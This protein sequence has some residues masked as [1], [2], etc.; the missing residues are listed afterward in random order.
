MFR[1]K[2]ANH[3]V[4]GPLSADAIRQLIASGV[5]GRNSLLQEGGTG[6]WQPAARFADFEPL[7]AAIDP[8]EAA[9]PS[10]QEATGSPSPPVERETPPTEGDSAAGLAVT[11]DRPDPS[12]PRTGEEQGAEPPDDRAPEPGVEPESGGEVRYLMIGGDGREYGPVSGQQICDW[13]R[14]HRADAR[15]RIRRM[16]GGDFTPLESWPE[17]AE[18]L[19]E[20][21][22]GKTPPRPPSLDSAQAERWAEEIIGRGVQFSVGNCFGRAWRL[23]TAHFG[24]LAGTTALA[25]VL[26]SVLHSVPG[27]GSV[28]AIALG[29]TFI[30]GLG[31]VFL[32]T[33]RGQR[34]EVNDL[35]AGFNRGFVPLLVA[36]TLVF[37]FVAAGLLLCLLP[38]IYLAVAW[39]FVFPLIYERSLDFWPAMELSRRVVHERWW[40]LFALVLGAGALVTVGL[41]LAVV[42]VFFTA[43]LAFGAIMYA[44]EDIFEG[45]PPRS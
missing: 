6:Y 41:L 20:V 13:I 32:K 28:V 17:F 21:G 22:Q 18:V 19:R 24:I 31:V 8:L 10:G 7:F 40:E 26:V 29:G 44:Y 9:D 14:Q 27:A 43:P 16:E 23:Y 45:G 5:I 35:F 42:G 30:A 39:L 25:L 38:G 3:Q 2:D 11:S 4:V 1:Y 12:G 33:I 15:T 34:A 36:S 37:I